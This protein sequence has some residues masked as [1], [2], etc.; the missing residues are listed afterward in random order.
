[1]PVD[2]KDN[3]ARAGMPDLDLLLE[4]GPTLQMHLW[5]ADAQ[6]WR[7][8]LPAR[9]AFSVGSHV[10][11]QGFVFNP[12]LHYQHDWNNWRFKSTFGPVYGSESYHD[13]FYQVD[14]AYVTADRS[15]FDSAGGLTGIRMSLGLNRRWGEFYGG[16]SVHYYQLDSAA[17]QESPLMKSNDYLSVSFMLV[18]VFLS[19]SEM[20]EI[21]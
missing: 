5:K 11:E 13:Y 4:A 16:A 2:N 9:V 12:R 8:D 19:S 15:Y 20:T 7:L 14:K 3:E 18:W 1:L 10:R 21:D 17:N 6:E